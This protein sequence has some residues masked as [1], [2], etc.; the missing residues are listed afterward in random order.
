MHF[1]TLIAFDKECCFLREIYKD[2]YTLCVQVILRDRFLFFV[3]LGIWSQN[4][5]LFVQSAK[6]DT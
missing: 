5:E 2:D 6:F 3:F 1:E 4:S